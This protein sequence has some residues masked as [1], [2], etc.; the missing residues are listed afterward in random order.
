LPLHLRTLKVEPLLK[1][2][3]HELFDTWQWRPIQNCPGRYKLAGASLF[4]PMEALIGGEKVMKFQVEGARDTV[5]VTRLKDGGVIS[6]RRR[7]GSYLHT[8]N[9]AEGFSRKLM[10]LGIVLDDHP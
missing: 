7:N 5:L 6:Y 10:Q 1:A 2:T 8:L 4:L 9:T 3:F